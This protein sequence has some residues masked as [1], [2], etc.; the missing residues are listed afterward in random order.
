MGKYHPTIIKHYWKE[1]NDN[2][3]YLSL[4]IQNQFIHIFG[5]YEKENILDRFQEVNY[6]VI[7]LDST[8]DISHTDQFHLSI[9]L[10]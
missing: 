4:K 8:L 7:E 6:I 10:C 5:N 9:C 1:V 3:R 2:R